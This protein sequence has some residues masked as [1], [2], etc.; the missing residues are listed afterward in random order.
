MKRIIPMMALILFWLSTNVFVFMVSAD[1]V[2][3]DVL[4]EDG[5]RLDYNPVLII[6]VSNDR[7]MDIFWYFKESQSDKWEN[8]GTNLSVLSGIYRQ[9]ISNGTEEG[10][11]Y[12]WRVDISDNSSFVTQTFNFRRRGWQTISAVK[13]IT[14]YVPD[15]IKNITVW[16]SG[17]NDFLIH[18]D[19]KFYNYSDEIFVRM[20][21][22]L[23]T[24]TF[25]ANKE[26]V[27]ENI[28]VVIRK[29][30]RMVFPPGY[31]NYISVFSMDDKKFDFSGEH[32]SQH[33]KWI[34]HIIGNG[35][36]LEFYILYATDWIRVLI[37]SI[38]LLAQIS[39]NII[40]WKKRKWEKYAIGSTTIVVGVLS[41]LLTADIPMLSIDMIIVFILSA[42]AMI[43]GFFHLVVMCKSSIKKHFRYAK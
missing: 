35:N 42:I 22:R 15:A 18:T 34:I 30:N 7:P 26:G 11:N 24:Q 12:Q 1:P 4:P 14:L 3:H 32:T 6:N 21:N 19:I 8:I 10:K 31:R 23:A 9:Q 39:F 16:M 25:T 41:S 17:E 27:Y 43:I 5:A 37:Y 33:G 29:E 2:I 20:P 13:N 40:S 28:C 36:R 38:L